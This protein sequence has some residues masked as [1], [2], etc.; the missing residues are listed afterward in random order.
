MLKGYVTVDEMRGL[1]ANSDYFGV[2][3][4][5]LMENAGRKAAE[6]IIAMCKHGRVLVACGT[7]NNGGDGFVIARFMAQAGYGV[8]VVIVGKAINVKPGP[9]VT[10]LDIIKSMGIP[11]IEVDSPD[12]ISREAFDEFD[13]IVDAIFGTGSHGVPR[14]PAK[15]IIKYINES[16][17]RKI[18]LD[19]P[20][21]LDAS[22]GLCVECVRPDMVITFHAPK[23]GLERYHFEVV[24]IG[25][26]KK[27]VTH[28]GPGDL[29]GLKSRGDFSD[30][31]GGGRLLIIGGGPYTGAPAFAALAAYRSGAEIVSVAAPQ[32]AADIIA[33][34]SPD[35][36]VWPLS[37]RDRV[38]E[39]DVEQLKA[40][41]ARHQ[42]VVIGMGLGRDP[43][44]LAA[45]AKILPLCGRAVIDADALQKGMDL[46][47]IIT[48]NVHEFNRLS[49]E[50]VE[51]NDPSAPE[52]VKRFSADA[53]VVTLW[54]GSPAVV[55]DGSNVKVNSTGNPGMSVGGVGDVLAGVTGAFY[56]RN[57]AFQAACAS[58]FI[59]GAA[60]DMAFEDK[61]YG[62]I[63][64]DVLNMI[65]YAMKKYR[66]Q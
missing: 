10:N 13:I 52:K 45:V 18:S 54:K 17:A 66:Q 51:P 39:A 25:I 27:A 9:A 31:G 28:I 20:S 21:G 12:K 35:L 4:G 38:V 58:A 57:P 42:A 47:G 7:G 30:K 40:L 5:E 59:T 41:I 22:T 50:Q 43:E 48:P 14:E 15:T 8:L 60:G 29:I 11:V 64:S 33:S 2:S 53:N 34:F 26:P 32:R 63:A 36:I 46:H 37:D 16:H 55:S 49:G 56:C 65:P 1:E 6:S 61:G 3:Y 44:T 23:I 62:L 19:I 24:D